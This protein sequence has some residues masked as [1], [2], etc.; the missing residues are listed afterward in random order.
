VSHL[1]ELRQLVGL[2]SSD[3]LAIAR[4]SVRLRLALEQ[5]GGAF[6]SWLRKASQSAENTQLLLPDFLSGFASGRVDH[7][8]YH[9]QYR[10]AVYWV[11]IGLDAGLAAAALSRLRALFVRTAAAWSA[12][13]TAEALCRLVDLT[14]AIHTVVFQLGHVLAQLERLAANDIARVRNNCK[15]LL[16]PDGDRL[17][18]AYVQHLEWKIRA[19]RLALDDAGEMHA[20]PLSPWECD[21][22]RW[23]QDGGL[24]MV[25][26]R[27]GEVV[28]RAHERLHRLVDTALDESRRGKPQA[29][30]K[31]LQ[32]IEEA[33]DDI[34]S[35]LGECISNRL[36]EVVVQDSLTRLGTRRL[37]DNDIA[38]QV[39]TRQGDGGPLALLLIDVDR[40]KKVNDRYG[41]AIG[42]EVL[43]MVADALLSSLRASDRPYRW[44][45][46][47]FA[48]LA[49]A[50]RSEDISM[51][52]ERIRSKVAARVISTADGDVRVTVSIGGTFA[53]IACA[54]DSNS[55]FASCD[56]N[57]RRAKEA[58]RNQVVVSEYS[59]LP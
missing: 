24:R 54:P 36:G 25:P 9:E 15:V 30:L 11:K 3:E 58:G 8:F 51:V 42:D 45:G 34:A 22:G 33:S 46:E 12:M 55:L 38:R 28:V 48:V 2:D 1:D 13:R 16:D 56:A 26:R 32:D 49:Q 6:E 29:I 19:Y 4:E 18:N 10:Q 53:A 27:R 40:F 7:H 21:L 43:Q 44:G 57:L 41:H 52:A 5:A 39:H 47:E 35:V 17:L 50:D 37:F 20:L 23:L 59:G 31:Y 14:C